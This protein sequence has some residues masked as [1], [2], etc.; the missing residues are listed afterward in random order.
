[1]DTP[2]GLTP[3]GLTRA[4]ET[5]AMAQSHRAEEMRGYLWGEGST[6]WFA[7]PENP[8]VNVEYK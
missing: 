2:I 7:D 1:M 4:F 6:R 8:C 3:T 5:P